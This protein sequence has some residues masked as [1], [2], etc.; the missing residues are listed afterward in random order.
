MV[1]IAQNNC[2]LVSQRRRL[3]HGSFPAGRIA[4]LTLRWKPAG[5][6]ANCQALFV[7]C[8]NVRVLNSQMLSKLIVLERQLKQRGIRLVL[9]D[10]RDEVHRVLRWTK[11]D[12]FFEINE[13]AERESV[14]LA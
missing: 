10:L 6:R 1:A 12:R 8:W 2:G 3:D 11:L 9:F 5:D 4:N 13:D 7:D 14:R